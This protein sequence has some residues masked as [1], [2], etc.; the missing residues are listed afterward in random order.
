[1]DN[2]LIQLLLYYIFLNFFFSFITYLFYPKYLEIVLK[3]FIYSTVPFIIRIIFTLL[4]HQILSQREINKSI[5]ENIL[6]ISISIV[7]YFF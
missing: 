2:L 6:F 7:N 1:M 3:F 5:F 4:I